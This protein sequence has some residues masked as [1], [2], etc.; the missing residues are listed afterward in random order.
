MN[1][2]RPND[3]DHVDKPEDWLHGSL[4]FGAAVGLMLEPG[5]G[6][7]V[8]IKGEMKNPV[9]SSNKVVVFHAGNMVHIDD[10]PQDLPEGTLCTIAQPTADEETPANG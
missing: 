9:G 10:F 7:V 1:Y 2:T 3:P 4:I 8:D 5:T 6:I